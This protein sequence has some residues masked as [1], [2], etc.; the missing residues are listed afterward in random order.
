MHFNIFFLRQRLK[1]SFWSQSTIKAV[2]FAASMTPAIF[3]CEGASLFQRL[4]PSL[5]KQ[6]RNNSCR[7]DKRCRWLKKKRLWKWSRCLQW[8]FKKE[9]T[10]PV[11]TFVTVFNTNDV[12][13][14]DSPWGLKIQ[15]HLAGMFSALEWQLDKCVTLPSTLSVIPLSSLEPWPEGAGKPRCNNKCHSLCLDFDPCHF[16]AFYN[17]ASGFTVK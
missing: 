14:T 16:P 17:T 15:G 1:F 12:S 10:I 6:F 9:K 2:H 8:Y 4:C 11:R 7:W 3:L 5:K 13:C